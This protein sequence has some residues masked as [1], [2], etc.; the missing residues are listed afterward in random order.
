MRVI[1][2]DGTKV[3][4]VADRGE[5]PDPD[6]GELVSMF[7]DA[8]KAFGFRESTIEKFI[9]IEDGVVISLA[10]YGYYQEV[11]E[12]VRGVMERK[13]VARKKARLN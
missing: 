11:R 4:T 13:V 6:I 1:I 7:V 10:E 2:D 12:G 9:P 5:E 3:Y 8:A